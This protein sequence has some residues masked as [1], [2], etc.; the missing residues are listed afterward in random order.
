MDDASN[1]PVLPGRTEPNYRR[2]TIIFSEA[3]SEALE[4]LVKG[5]DQRNW[6][7]PS[8]SSIVRALVRMASDGM[9]KKGELS[10]YIGPI[11]EAHLTV[12]SGRLHL[13]SVHDVIDFVPDDPQD[14]QSMITKRRQQLR[15][16]RAV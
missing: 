13:H 16:V 15:I 8:R 6:V 14:R 1:P 4:D 12:H 5:A 11:L 10:P 3:D 9:N 7:K 2:T